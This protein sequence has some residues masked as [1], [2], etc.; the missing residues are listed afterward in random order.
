LAA[1]E[2]GKVVV[3]EGRMGRAEKGFFLMMGR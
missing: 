2:R 3:E 1:V